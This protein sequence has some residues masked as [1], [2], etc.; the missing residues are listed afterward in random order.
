M[1]Q[2]ITTE[3][4]ATKLAISPRSITRMA[5]EGRFPYYIIG[6]RM[7]FVEDEV[8]A[9]LNSERCRVKSRLEAE[10]EVFRNTP[11][12]REVHKMPIFGF[13]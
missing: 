13:N 10:R 4:L 3:E 2:Y 8:E 9:H 1:K 5:K 7:R 11:R 12:K 6:K